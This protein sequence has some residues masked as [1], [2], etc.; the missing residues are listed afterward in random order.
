MVTGLVSAAIVTAVANAFGAPW[1]AVLFTLVSIAAVAAMFEN[2]TFWSISYSFGYLVCII[3]FG[4]Y[5]LEW[6]ELV[7]YGIA[8]AA[9][10]FVKVRNAF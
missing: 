10:I 4:Q 8:L 5:F 6:W 7:L 2:A 9:V 1:V 3:L